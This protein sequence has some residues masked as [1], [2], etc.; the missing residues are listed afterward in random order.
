M[1]DFKR[2]FDK[3]LNAIMKLEAETLGLF[4]FKNSEV[5]RR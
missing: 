4:V 3:S 5:Q 1:L 2:K